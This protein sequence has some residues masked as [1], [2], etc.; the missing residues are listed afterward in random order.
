MKPRAAYGTVKEKLIAFEKIP[1]V[2]NWLDGSDLKPSTREYYAQRLFQFLREEEP[3]QFI[4]RALQ[5]PRTVAIEIKGKV[6][7]AAAKHGPSSAF[8]M[9][10]SVKSFLEYYETGVHIVGKLKVRRRWQKPY[11]SWQDAERIIAKCRQPYE[12]VFRFMLWAGLGSD[13]VL[14]INSSPAIQADI[15]KQLK[16]SKDHVIIDLEPRKQTLTR[17]FTAVPKQYLPKF[18]VHTLDYR[19]R[20]NKLITRQVLEDRFRKAARQVGL[21]QPGMG[22][23]TLRSVFTSQCAMA[24]VRESVCEFMKGH[25]AG[26]KYGYSREVLNEEYVV[27]EL[28]KLWEPATVSKE[29]V[30]RLKSEMDELRKGKGFNEEDVRRMVEQYLAKR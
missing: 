17:Y 23:H 18:P 24:G 30:D 13:E 12:S 20:G 27:K 6:A 26:D 4:K 8:H 11:L 2:K 7:E 3:K 25:G 5:N 19:I 14:E 21:Y 22:P 1:E 16:G 29:E 9:R 10:A 15:E 28:R